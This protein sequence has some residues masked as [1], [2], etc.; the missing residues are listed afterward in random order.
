MSLCYDFQ[1][2]M[3]ITFA[4]IATVLIIGLVGLVYGQT[5]MDEANKIIEEKLGNATY[6]DDPATTWNETA[7][8][9]RTEA[10]IVK[11]REQQQAM[12]AIKETYEFI[13]NNCYQ[14]SDRP[15]YEMMS[16]DSGQEY[17][18]GKHATFVVQ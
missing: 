8:P 5:L 3:I 17:S 9:E 13:I 14:H 18:F 2:H 1:K 10:E 6:I 16:P 7:D 4:A 12:N 11:K 15:G